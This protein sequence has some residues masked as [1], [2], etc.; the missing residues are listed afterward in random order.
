ML[1]LPERIMVVGGG[2]IAVEFAGIFNG[3]GAKTTLSYRGPVILRGFDMDLRATLQTEM[4][5]KG[6]AVETETD[7]VTIEKIKS[8]GQ[9]AFD[10]IFKDGDHIETDLVMYATG[11]WPNTKGLGL[12][13]AGVA[14]GP[15]GE[16]QGR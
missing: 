10:V 11:R 2:Y 5:K 16:V 15:K 13:A 14:L 4:G 6:I 9:D 3:L 1:E 8:G 7:I 12:E